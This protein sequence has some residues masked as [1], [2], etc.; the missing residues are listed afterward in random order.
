[1]MFLGKVFVSLFISSSFVRA[2]IYGHESKTCVVKPACDGS[3]DAPAIIKAFHRCGKNGRVVFLNETYNIQTIM[4]T[5]GLE[6]C[7]VD[8]KGTMLVCGIKSELLELI[9]KVEY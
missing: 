1:M 8:L 9:V 2:G 4:N 3:D 7:E 6:N 5:T